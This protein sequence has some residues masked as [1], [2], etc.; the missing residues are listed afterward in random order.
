M[1]QPSHMSFG[2]TRESLSVTALYAALT[3]LFAYPLSFSPGSTSLGADADVHTMTWTLA[4]GAHALFHEPLS[5]FDANIF[6]P[7]DRTLAFSENLIGSAVIAAPVLWLTDNSV[8]AMNVVS[9]V[10]CVLC[11]VGAYLLGRQVGLGR[12]AAIV[13]GLIFA[14]S[15]A[16]FFRFGQIH[17]TT[18]QW[19]PFA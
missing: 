19:M 18:I 11:G 17:L 15:P 4:W 16:R 3:L 13:C 8:L 2:S 9:L 14:F 1:A 12:A 5:I 6:Y 7:Y 10:S